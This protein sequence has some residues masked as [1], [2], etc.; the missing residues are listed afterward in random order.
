MSESLL[1]NLPQ[2]P[3]M[4]LVAD[5]ADTFHELACALEIAAPHL[6]LHGHDA[7]VA[8]S[9]PAY[10]LFPSFPATLTKR[11]PRDPCPF[12]SGLRSGAGMPI[13]TPPRRPDFA[14][15]CRHRRAEERIGALAPPARRNLSGPH[16]E[17]GSNERPQTETA[18]PH[19]RF[20]G[21]PA[22]RSAKLK[23]IIQRQR[24][25][26]AEVYRQLG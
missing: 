12:A 21:L 3:T 10:M 7:A 1:P 22:D 24:A 16:R 15:P 11:Q 6:P 8:I 5:A 19:R 14:A 25:V 20:G 17:V 13:R 4:D 9:L 26:V 2:N 18:P 23:K